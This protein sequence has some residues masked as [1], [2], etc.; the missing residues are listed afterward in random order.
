MRDRVMTAVSACGPIPYALQACWSKNPSYEL[1]VLPHVS[2]TPTTQR[3]RQHKAEF[4]DH[5][6]DYVEYGRIGS[7]R[8]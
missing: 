7:E 6:Y 4:S 8:T 3:L 1:Q 2:E 5:A